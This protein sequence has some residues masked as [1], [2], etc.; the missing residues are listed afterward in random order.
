M[1]RQFEMAYGAR[2]MRRLSAEMMVLVKRLNRVHTEPLTREEVLDTQSMLR[3]AVAEMRLVAGDLE[4]WQEEP[5]KKFW[6]FWK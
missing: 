2:Q 5:K 1:N 4:D 6:Q 3:E